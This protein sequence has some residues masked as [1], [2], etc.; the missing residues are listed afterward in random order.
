MMHSY[1]PYFTR[2]ETEA[3]KVIYKL[4]RITW[5][6]LG[7]WDLNLR[8]SVLESIF[9]PYALLPT[10]ANPPACILRYLSVRLCL[11]C[12]LTQ[13]PYLFLSVPPIPFVFP[14]VVVSSPSYVQLFVTPMD[15]SLP[16]S[17]VLEWFATSFSRDLPDPGIKPTFPA[18]AGGFFTAQPD[19]ESPYSVQLISFPHNFPN[20]FVPSFNSLL[21]WI[22]DSLSW[23]V[24]L[25]LTHFFSVSL[26]NSSFS[27]LSFSHPT[28]CPHEYTD[29]SNCNI[30]LLTFWKLQF[31]LHSTYLHLN[32][33]R[34]PTVHISNTGTYSFATE[35]S[36]TETPP[37]L[38]QLLKPEIQAWSLSS[39]SLSF[40]PKPL[41][42]TKFCLFYFINNYCIHFF[43][44]WIP[45]VRVLFASCVTIET[46]SKLVFLMPVFPLLTPVLCPHQHF[47]N[48]KVK[49]LVV[50]SCPILCDPMD[51]SM[52][53]SCVHGILRARIL[54][55]VAFPFSRGSPQPRDQ[56]Q[57]S[58]TAG[59][60]FTIWATREAS[61]LRGHH[62]QYT[63]QSEVYGLHMR[64]FAAKSYILFFKWLCVI[65]AIIH[66]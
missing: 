33:H 14:F 4:L 48:L 54:E 15:C 64:N 16:G 51:C 11:L 58:H 28:H 20:N 44:F 24:C 62:F 6:K 42:I 29:P 36:L 8:S 55:W 46:G 49:V 25:F 12:F 22:W 31:R 30:Y 57:V 3:Q 45:L 38:T 1:C 65:N 34:H 47:S 32:V 26:L 66:P 23:I 43:L 52:P 61:N 2:E 5:L 41:D 27:T 17:S 60:F 53:G 10:L 50:Q 19:Q 9:Q 40:K 21:P 35:R 37:S 63:S 13:K 18:L 56:I 39:R 7:S 59:G